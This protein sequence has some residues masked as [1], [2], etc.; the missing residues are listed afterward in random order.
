MS[1]APTRCRRSGEP[2][3]LVS[4]R[5]VRQL[6]TAQAHSNPVKLMV[7]VA[8]IGLLAAA[9]GCAHGKESPFL[10]VRVLSRTSACGYE[11]AENTPHLLVI[12]EGR[13]VCS[14][15]HV[16]QWPRMT[17]GDVLRQVS[18]PGGR[19][20]SAHI[21]SKDP[22][23]HRTLKGNDGLNEDVTDAFVITVK[24]ASSPKRAQPVE[25]RCMHS[26][27][28]GIHSAQPGLS[29]DAPAA[30]SWIDIV[31]GNGCGIAASPNDGKPPSP[32]NIRFRVSTAL[33]QAAGRGINRYFVCGDAA[34]FGWNVFDPGPENFASASVATLTTAS[35]TWYVLRTDETPYTLTRIA[36][37]TIRSGDVIIVPPRTQICP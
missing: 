6:P 7:L 27:W 8:A 23:R 11:P 32:A 22:E 18:P 4:R 13:N 25:Y 19:V 37:Q 12:Y 1:T 28:D 16:R 15:Q 14:G 9:Q 10:H 5:N 3:V 36:G 29:N 26:P 21:T 34:N 20:L 24:M 2:D 33:S 17:L 31:P 35:P 30:G